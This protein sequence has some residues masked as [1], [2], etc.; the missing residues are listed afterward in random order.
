MPS[1]TPNAN[2]YNRDSSRNEGLFITDLYGPL[3]LGLSVG[4]QWMLV[5]LLFWGPLPALPAQINELTVLGAFWFKPERDLCVYLAGCVLTTIGTV[6]L[7][8]LWKVHFRIEPASQKKRFATAAA[9]VQLLLGGTSFALFATLLPVLRPMVANDRVIFSLVGF[10]LLLIPGIV[11]L[12]MGTFC[13][14]FV[15]SVAGLG[16]GK[17]VF[18]GWETLL[19]SPGQDS[20]K[21]NRGMMEAAMDVLIPL[22]VCVIIYVPPWRELAGLFFLRDEFHHWDYFT[23]GPA[24]AFSHHLALG[25]DVYAQ[26]GVGWP[27]LLSAISPIAPLSYGLVVNIAIVY[28]CAYFAGIYLLLRLFFKDVTWALIGVIIAITLQLFRGIE[29]GAVLWQYPSSTVIRAPFDVWFF[30][31]ILM[32]MRSQR[33]FWALTTGL[34]VG[35]A[36]LFE[37]ETGLYL[38]AA[39]ACFFLVSVP[40]FV[41]R[42]LKTHF[43]CACVSCSTAAI[44]CCLGLVIASRGTL[45]HAEFWAGWGE[46]IFKYSAGIS[47][48]PIAGVPNT[49][50]LLF[51]MFLVAY[52]FCFTRMLIAS[53][54]WEISA[55]DLFLGCLSFY[56]LLTLILFIGRS[57][58]YNIYHVSVPFAVVLV[59]SLERMHERLLIRFGW[60]PSAM[61]RAFP[62]ACAAGACVGLFSQSAFQSYPN[63]FWILRHGFPDQGLSLSHTGI[64]GI[65]PAALRFADQFDVITARMRDLTESDR[66]IAIFDHADTKYYLSSG[67]VP[68]SRY[69][70]LMPSLLAKAQ[71]EKLK[72][73]LLERHPDYVFLSN[74][75]KGVQAHGEVDTWTI[76]RDTLKQHYVLENNTGLFEVWHP[77]R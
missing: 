67:A 6:G 52:L 36:L 14:R 27:M 64:R 48:L 10:T 72:K 34:T 19:G 70:P 3:S 20:S 74:N 11:S 43:K 59:A 26:Y 18:E 42:D 15:V 37:T 55:S 60:L 30:V 13:L 53:L 46:A 62:L 56:G 35:L 47:M 8:W 63:L 5:A 57:H 50:L 41:S 1:D 65:P 75:L 2:S 69:S 31:A 33:I 28:G 21:R 77:I 38:C 58:P 73:E 23:M 39:W 25:T 32:Y 45:L 9:T 68:W 4:I 44:A 61:R 12:I 17:N 71:V 29:P 16:F 51:A 24:L 54:Q 40:F 66:S 7:V 22:L 49:T 76:L